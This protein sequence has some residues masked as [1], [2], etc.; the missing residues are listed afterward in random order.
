MRNHDFFGIKNRRHG[1]YTRAVLSGIAFP[2]F[3]AFLP[4]PLMAQ[5]APALKASSS[6]FTPLSAPTTHYATVQEA[7][8]TGKQAVHE[9]RWADATTAFLAAEA[10]TSNPQTQ[11]LLAK[12]VEYVEARR[13]A[14]GSAPAET[15]TP[16]ASNSIPPMV[17]P[18]SAMDVSKIKVPPVPSGAYRPGN[19]G[20]QAVLVFHGDVGEYLINPITVL[21][22]FNPGFGGGAGY[23]API[24]SHFKLG[25]DLDYLSYSNTRT[26]ATTVSTGFPPTIQTVSTTLS[27]TES[28]WQV[29]LD[30]QLD[31]SAPHGDYSYLLMGLGA[32]FQSFSGNGSTVSSTSPLVRLG[33]GGN[34]IERKGFCAFMEVRFNLIF[35]GQSSSGSLSVPSGMILEVPVNIG[36]GID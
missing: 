21:E 11:A 34:L 33:A 26:Q 5:N 4:L 20:G 16:E 1:F 25:P 36:I 35:L 8:A 18:R 32:A 31:L 30:G 17:S 27:M 24:G 9:Q 15:G 7:F 13:S 10:M 29:S 23:F 14:A 22:S 2:L 28:D 3:L 12:W 6:V 19:F